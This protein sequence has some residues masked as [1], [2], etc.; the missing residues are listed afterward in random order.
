MLASQRIAL[1]MSESRKGIN[2]FPEDGDDDKR[3]E[4]TKRYQS[5]ESQYR[6]ALVLEDTQEVDS[7][8]HTAEGREL[9]RMRDRASL[10]D[11]VREAMGGGA[12]VS[13]AA[14]EFREAVL[15]EDMGGYMPVDMLEE[16]ADAVSNIGAAIQDNQM[17]IFERVF[18]RGS[19][20]YLGVMMPSVPVGS[21]SYPR[22]N[23]G[24]TGDVRSDGVELDGAA[25]SLETK[26]L[27]PVRLTA[28]YTY[29]VESLSRVMG[30]EEALRR[31]L[32]SVLMDKRDSLAING[33]AAVANVSPKI[34]GI[35]NSLTD[36]ANPTDEATWE[37]YLG[38]FD[39]MVDGRY[40]I[41]SEEVRLLLNSNVYRHAMSQTI[42]SIISPTSGA[43]H[44]LLRDRLPMDRFR[45]SGNMPATV[46][47]IATVIAYAVGAMARGFYM[48]SWRGIQF[49]IDPYTKAKAGQIVLTAV[50][51]TGFDM[52][53]GAGYKRVEFKTA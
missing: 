10:T 16:R 27:N 38:A 18:N 48:P 46:N 43:G 19:S 24:T 50:N 12:L 37:D 44:G 29:G 23:A 36:P 21:T 49:V 40:A 7:E 39:D 53:D 34:N 14:K 42:S 31:D 41:S 3:D 35:I 28:S 26:E 52:I 13:G 6:A 1:E 25:A 4:L 32:T 11:F 30:F 47:D 17:P 2:D 20:A 5:L 9:G 51:V 22:L 15:G 8:G 33:Q 45:V